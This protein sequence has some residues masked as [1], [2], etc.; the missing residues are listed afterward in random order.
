MMLHSHSP[1]SHFCLDH[2]ASF[3]PH[4]AYEGVDVKGIFHTHSLQ[5][6]V[7]HDK[8]SRSAHPSTAVNQ[9]RRAL[10]VREV[11]ANSFD[12]LYEAGFVCRHTM[13]RPCR[14]M[15][16]GHGQRCV[17][18]IFSL[19]G[20]SHNWDTCHMFRRLLKCNK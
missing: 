14:V 19:Q 9:E 17:V 20:K 12:E 8:S 6:A 15:E 18:F 3:L 1:N 13:I 7:K 11:F 16:V 4:F 2:E 10:V 5:H